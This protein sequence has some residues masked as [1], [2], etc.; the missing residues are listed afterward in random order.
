MI[1]TVICV[2]LL[3]VA[4][5]K[6]RQKQNVW[7]LF[8]L[9]FYMSNGYLI[10]LG[11]SI[12]KFQDF[13]L[14]QIVICCLIGWSRDGSFFSIRNRRGAAISASFI[15]FFIFELIYTYLNG[16]EVLGNIITTTRIYLYALV[17]FIFRDITET[18]I[19]NALKIIYKFS[20]FACLIFVIQFFT[21]IELTN[22]YISETNQYIG[23]YRMQSTPPYIALILLV[24][25]FYLRNIRYRLF[26]IL[27][28]LSVM[29]I[30]Q[31]RTPLITL[32]F[33]IIVFLV[34]AKDVKYKSQIILFCILLFPS[35]NSLMSSR[36]Q[37]EKSAITTNANVLDY[38]GSGDYQALSE[39]NTFL[40]RIAMLLERLD[41]IISTPQYTL[42][43]VGAMHEST[44]QKKFDFRV[45]TAGQG[46]DG[47]TYVNQLDSIDIVWS[48]I[49]IRYG[50]IGLFFHLCILLWIIVKFF[51]RRNNMI[52][53]LG[54]LSY[55]GGMVSSFSSGGMFLAGGIMTISLYL[56]AFDRQLEL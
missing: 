46:N 32:L 53:M 31:N 20:V 49:L 28:I 29:F 17:Y 35:F 5:S 42:F 51:K 43:G 44:A 16:Y 38:V 11:D 24:L 10:N 50:L 13:G 48:P 27:L 40:F 26:V 18:D 12:I 15:I 1:A 52:M 45:G 6:Y 23:I 8:I 3:F 37:E 36:S 56:I 54:F 33:Q 47:L 21:H 22:S 30:S 7:P 39:G 9:T 14:L 34:L 25:L 4:I 19:K 55:L 2:I 41:Y